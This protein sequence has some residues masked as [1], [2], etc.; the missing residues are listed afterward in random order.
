VIAE[1]EADLK[2]MVEEPYR[3]VPPFRPEP[4]LSVVR[5]AIQ[6]LCQAKRPVIVAGGGVTISQAGPELVEL[7]VALNPQAN[8]I[9]GMGFLRRNGAFYEMQAA[10]KKG[11]LT[12]NGA[13]MP[14]PLPA[15]Q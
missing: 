1:G 9:I 15:V 5:E 12:V 13:P 6:M 14:V 2:V 4:E 10:Y 8:A 7:A 3:Q 11:L